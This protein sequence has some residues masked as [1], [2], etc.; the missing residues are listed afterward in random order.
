V[1]HK[2]SSTDGQT[3]EYSPISGQRFY[4]FLMM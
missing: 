3:H 2:V 1:F 4:G